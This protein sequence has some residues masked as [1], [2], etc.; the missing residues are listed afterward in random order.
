M[1][2]YVLLSNRY[3]S[4][5]MVHS[6]GYLQIFAMYPN[7]ICNTASKW[8]FGWDSTASRHEKGVGFCGK[9]VKFCVPWKAAY[10]L[11]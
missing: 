9:L 10:S 2:Q 7:K 1:V 5:Y 3:S 4:P 6:I 11:A 8:W